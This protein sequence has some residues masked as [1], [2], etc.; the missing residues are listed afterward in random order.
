MNAIR[1]DVTLPV[2]RL[3]LGPF[4]VDPLEQLV[5]A[6]VSDLLEPLMRGPQTQRRTEAGV[7][8]DVY[9]L[10]LPD[11]EGAAIPLGSFGELGF[12][13]DR[14]VLLL[15]VPA[16]SA[17]FV[18]PRLGDSLLGPPERGMS[19]D[20]RSRIVNLRVKLEAGAK[21]AF[22]LGSFGEIGIEAA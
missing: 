12:F 3:G 17:P 9:P 14:S 21:A 2:L 16:L 15:T 8:V 4:V 18:V 1:V 7:L 13:N 5:G 22:P 6:R 20:G 10:A 11:G 19:T